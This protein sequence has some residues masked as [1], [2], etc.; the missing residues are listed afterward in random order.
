[1]VDLI[2]EVDPSE[3]QESPYTAYTPPAM[4]HGDTFDQ[5]LNDVWA[6]IHDAYQPDPYVKMGV[7][8]QPGVGKTWF[9]AS[10]PN[11]LIIDCHEEGSKFLPQG[12]FKDVKV[13]NCR[14]IKQVELVYF[15]LRQGNHD[16]KTVVIDTV[17]SLIDMGMKYQL[18]PDEDEWTIS[19]S[20][21]LPRWDA[22]NSVNSNVGDLLWYFL[23]LPMNVVILAH[24]R[25]RRD[26]DTA[27][28][29]SEGYLSPRLFPDVNPG[30]RKRL[31]GSVDIL[32]RMVLRELTFKNKDPEKPNIKRLA[33][34]LYVRPSPDFQAKDRT[35]VLS[36]AAY[37]V[38]PTYAKLEA[39]LRQLAN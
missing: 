33:R 35:D 36:K 14:H 9:G 12:R 26:D 16:F 17:T 19:R 22:W 18:N 11:V 4:R 34:V 1:V 25:E 7:Y 32:G 31:Y 37:I 28:D 30:I 2:Q 13:V 29:M 27:I 8:G 38:D 5:D 6:M 23:T 10:W 3:I 21:N 39:Q 15:G 24:E 20:P